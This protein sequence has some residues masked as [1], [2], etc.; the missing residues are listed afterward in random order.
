MG[1][2]GGQ[3]ESGK[4]SWVRDLLLYFLG[5]DV[6]SFLVL[7]QTD[8]NNRLSYAAPGINKHGLWGE[9]LKYNGLSVM[10]HCPHPDNYLSKRHFPDYN[11]TDFISGLFPND[12]WSGQ[13][14]FAST[15]DGLM[16]R[17]G[18]G[19]IL[20]KSRESSDRVK[21]VALRI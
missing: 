11:F 19:L 20:I 15:L 7:T 8:T 3:V 6:P 21:D 4:R 5:T 1:R 14:R 18:Y 10:V 2:G 9:Q 13:V 17:F 12:D 16:G